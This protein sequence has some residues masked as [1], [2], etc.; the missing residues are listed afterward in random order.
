[1]RIEQITKWSSIRELARRTKAGLFGSSLVLVKSVDW[2]KEQYHEFMTEFGQPTTQHPG[3]NSSVLVLNGGEGDPD[4]WFNQTFSMRMHFDGVNCIANYGHMPLNFLYAKNLENVHGGLTLF[5]STLDLMDEV[6]DDPVLSELDWSKITGRYTSVSYQK[7]TLRRDLPELPILARSKYS[8]QEYLVIDQT[9]TTA[10][11]QDG[12]PLDEKYLHRYWK[13]IDTN[14]FR[15]V[16]EQGDL[17]VWP[18]DEFLHGRTPTYSG[19]R[20]LWRGIVLEGP[21]FATN[22]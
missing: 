19:T 17:L 8:E 4:F 16:W 2:T 1:M 7:D 13:L 9:N 15:F 11:V 21:S 3:H 18:N 5:R 14:R 12:V 6:R 22:P 20:V 10:L